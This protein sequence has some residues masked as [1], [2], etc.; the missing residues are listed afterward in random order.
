VNKNIAA[1]RMSVIRR[2]RQ[3]QLE[4]YQP[5]ETADQALLAFRRLKTGFRARWKIMAI[6]MK[7]WGR[8]IPPGRCN[9]EQARLSITS[10]ARISVTSDGYYG[11]GRRFIYMRI[12]T[13]SV[14][15]NIEKQRADSVTRT[16]GLWN[17][18]NMERDCPLGRCWTV[19]W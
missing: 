5:Q 3:Q 11:Y 4:D 1:T 6:Q 8:M 7:G 9:G 15:L 17:M 18:P 16:L 12:R 10:G 2:E 19:K 14:I 13:A